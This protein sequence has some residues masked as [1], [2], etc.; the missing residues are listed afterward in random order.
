MSLET[1]SSIIRFQPFVFVR[2]LVQIY[3]SITLNFIILC[4]LLINIIFLNTKLILIWHK[5]GTLKR[6]FSLLTNS[7]LKETDT[8][9]MCQNPSWHISTFLDIIHLFYQCHRWIE[10]FSRVTIQ[11]HSANRKGSICCSY[12]YVWNIQV[13]A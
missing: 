2:I 7:F 13:Y 6:I 8:F 4:Q 5:G 3:R 12:T 10:V 9:I 11:L 1:I